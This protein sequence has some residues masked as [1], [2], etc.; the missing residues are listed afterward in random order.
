MDTW[1]ASQKVIEAIDKLGK[2]Y[3][4]SLKKNGLVDDTPGQED[5]KS[6]ESLRWKPTELHSGKTIKIQTF[7]K[8]KKVGS[9]LLTMLN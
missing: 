2:I 5:Y 3:Y 4:S 8:F 1:Y 9:S 7:P 6:V